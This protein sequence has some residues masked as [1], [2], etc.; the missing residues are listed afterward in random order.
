MHFPAILHNY[1]GM[2]AYI[3]RRFISTTAFL[4]NI[5]LKE[6]QNCGVIGGLA[7]RYHGGIFDQKRTVGVRLM[8][9]LSRGAHQLILPPGAE[10]PSYATGPLHQFQVALLVQ[11]FQF[12][13]EEAKYWY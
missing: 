10:N 1:N 6:N 12:L 8:R 5:L 4:V 13:A 7:Q 2:T 9:G 3:C 11:L